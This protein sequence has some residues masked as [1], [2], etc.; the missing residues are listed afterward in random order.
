[1]LIKY[2]KF[3][4]DKRIDKSKSTKPLIH[5]D[6]DSIIKDCITRKNQGIKRINKDRQ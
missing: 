3:P 1:M 2:G 4:I 6:F 5:K